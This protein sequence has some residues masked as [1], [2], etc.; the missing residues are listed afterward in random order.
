MQDKCPTSYTIAFVPLLYSLEF[1]KNYAFC[2]IS[3]FVTIL[4]TCV[5]I[6][7]LITT[8]CIIF[9]SQLAQLPYQSVVGHDSN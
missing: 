9:M 8:G 7:F 1:Y 6:I 2:C 3:D 5:K 4:I